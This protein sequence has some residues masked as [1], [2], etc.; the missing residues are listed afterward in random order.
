MVWFVLKYSWIDAVSFYV[1]IFI[2][3]NTGYTSLGCWKD[4]SNRAIPILEGSSPF[5]N[6][7]YVRRVDAIQKCYQAA[8]SLGAD[9]FAVQ[10]GGWCGSSGTAKSTYKKYGVSTDC[11]SDGEGGPWANQVYQIIKG[12]V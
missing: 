11:G 8:K 10:H 1:V 4:N 9:V 6:G 2:P 3:F 12:N 5:L 7:N